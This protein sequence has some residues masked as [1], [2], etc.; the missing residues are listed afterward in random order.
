MS[1]NLVGNIKARNVLIM[2]ERR[3]QITSQSQA[4]TIAV[5]KALARNLRSQD[6]VALEGELGA[7]KT[8]FVR[9][10]ASGLNINPNQ[11][12]SPTFVLRQEYESTDPLNPTLVHI[13]AYRLSGPEELE[14]IGWQELLKDDDVVIAVEWPSRIATALPA[15]RIDVRIQHN[16]STTRSIVLSVPEGLADRLQHLDSSSARS[17]QM[18]KCRTCERTFSAESDTFP[19]CSERC[20]L[21]DLGK[22]F[23][24]SYRVSREAQADEELDV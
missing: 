17:A 12:S 2:A 8:I 4:Q 13:D 3:I 11:V 9:G 21:A 19:F 7:G 18:I 20:R 1:A 5:A 23:S 14:S 24:E 10:L 6:V 16:N 22:W 15:Q